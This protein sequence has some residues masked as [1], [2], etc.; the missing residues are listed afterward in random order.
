[1]HVFAFVDYD[2]VKP[3]RKERQLVDVEDNIEEIVR[4]LTS[5]SRVAFPRCNE[6]I[7]RL[8]G[9]WTDSANTHTA[10]G[11]WIYAA[12]A[13]IR[14]RRN[15]LRVRPEVAVSNLHSDLPQLVGLYRDGGQKMVDTL[16]VADMIW[17]AREY[18]APLVVMSDDEDMLPGV[19]A[20]S[21]LSCDILL[22]RRRE[23]GAALNDDLI[24]NMK[25]KLE[26]C[27]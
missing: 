26:R 19:I 20:A 21:I 11:R 2:N 15:G 23:V 22:L 3:L 13:G 17:V 4:V 8:Y 24:V 25:V 14:G 6:L 1:M 27:Y 7:V 9:G 16:L 10:A 18:G 5:M 12:A